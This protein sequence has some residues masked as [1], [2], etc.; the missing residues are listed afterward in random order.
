M[1]DTP[2]EIDELIDTV[3]AGPASA[4]VD[5]R[6]ATSHKLSDL[7]DIRND[8]AAQE[9]SGTSKFGLRF[10]KLVPGGCG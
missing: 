5:G 6:S 2:S 4:S 7:K 3:A 10:T 9:A 8:R 1:P